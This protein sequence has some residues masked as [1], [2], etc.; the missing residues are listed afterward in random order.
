MGRVGGVW[1][2]GVGLVLWLFSSLF[3]LVQIQHKFVDSASQGL[4]EFH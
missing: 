2:I 3:E 4:N 1:S